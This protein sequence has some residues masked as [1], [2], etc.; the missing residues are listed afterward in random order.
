MSSERSR[1]ELASL[2]VAAAAGFAVLTA[3]TALTGVL[4]G[5]RWLG[6]VLLTVTVVSVVG[7]VLRSGRLPV[8]LVA[9]GQVA[10]LTGL[11]TALFTRSGIL[12]VLPGP[13][14]LRELGVVLTA[15]AGQVRV[16]VPPVP[17]TT[18]LLCLV[19]VAVGLVAVL[20]DTLAVAAAAPAVSGLVLLCLVTVPASLVNELLPW[21]TF[22]LGA[23]GF[24]LLL[25]VDG[26]RQRL[27]WD[28]SAG[29][30][31]PSAAGS[32]AGVGALA[33][34]VALLAGSA[35]TAVGTDGRLPGNRF[36][37]EAGS[38]AIGLNPFTSLRGQLDNEDPV[39][40][41]WVRGLQDRAYLRALT[42]S[43]FRN[44]QGWLRGPMDGA[45]QADGTV[46]LPPG[47]T[48]PL[49]G[50]VV[51][52]QI[53]SIDYVDTW[54]PTFGVP[55]TFNGLTADWRYDP[56]ALTAFSTQRQR[57]APYTVQSLLPQPDPAMVRTLATNAPAG[58]AASAAEVGSPFSEP[59]REF[60]D[61]GG[62]DPRVS[63]LAARVTAGTQTPFDA[64]LTLNAFFTEPGN[65]FSYELQTPP[66]SN[67]DA[68]VDFLFDG[69]AGYCEQYASAMAIM[70]RTL[71]I[72][73]RV[74]VGFTP[75][76]ATGDSRLITTADA[77]AWV[78]VWFPGAGWLTFDPTPLSDGRTV[79]PP[80]VAEGLT[81]ASALP[82]PTDQAVPTPNTEPAA[83]PSTDPRA[84]RAQGTGGGY[85]GRL[86][87]GA[88]VLLVL[89]AVVAL[90]PA[91]L[92]ALQRRQRLRLAAAGGPTAAAAAWEE[93]LAEFRDRGAEMP[94]TGTV[95]T[96]AGRLAREHALDEQG[97]AALRALVIA[98]ERA[99]YGAAVPGDLR[100][101]V[102]L[103]TVQASLTRCAPLGRRARLLPR[104]VLTPFPWSQPR[105]SS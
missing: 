42:L 21:W 73:A 93:V 20:V 38:A 81:P 58:D 8:P 11:L 53:E 79:V 31:T 87:L 40:L 97:W 56:R 4:T 88:V 48:S 89:A 101:P 25:S 26:Q 78:E 77:H 74:A 41:F 67:G 71:G 92:R 75:G 54:L 76:I 59:G 95:R 10:A 18:E 36:G 2:P 30:A 50:A 43:T 105:G 61:T 16:G 47:L 39:D 86:G 64:T 94:M 7:M 68:L 34:V 29:S 84:D 55:L 5:A 63:E 51:E 9:A 60:L 35:V 62:V 46:P 17:A 102:L 49:P 69:R 57:A 83:G 33:L 27:G 98:V 72:P 32:A 12:A 15:A 19:V 99:W 103:E 80:Y 65:G 66:A 37:G 3:A 96:I 52:V 100:L 44:G 6:F 45:V 82:V 28:G 104:S 85:V 13:D 70:L 22:T 90:F 14:A 1:L 23:L 24:V 91:A